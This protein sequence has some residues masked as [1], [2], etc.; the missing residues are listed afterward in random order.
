[1]Y[2]PS[3]ICIELCP[4]LKGLHCQAFK[5][6][7][8]NLI[9]WAEEPRPILSAICDDLMNGHALTHANWDRPLSRSNSVDS[10]AK[11]LVSVHHSNQRREE[12]TNECTVSVACSRRCVRT[13]DSEQHTRC[14]C[15]FS[16]TKIGC[17]VSL[18]VSVSV[19]IALRSMSN[20]RILGALFL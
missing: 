11:R 10:D 13:T 15:R 2:G 5:A 17:D 14:G 6:I 19:T 9:L 16:H 18:T 1:M 12:A 20:N 8:S 4:Q 7:L 3:T